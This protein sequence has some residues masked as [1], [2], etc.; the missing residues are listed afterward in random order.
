VDTAD[1][2]RR[3]VTLPDL[4][5]LVRALGH[6]T[7][8]QELPREALPVAVEAAAVVGSAGSFDWLAVLAGP[9]AARR[10]SSAL[11]GRGRL[12]G[13]L[14][15]DPA[16]GRL[17]IAVTLDRTA[18]S[19]ITCHAPSAA[20]LERLRRLRAASSSEGAAFAVRAVEIV[21]SEDVGRRFFHAFRATLD[22]MT[23]GV[24]G[25][26]RAE[27]RRSLALIQLT[28]V[29]F[30]Y[31]VQAKGWLDGRPDFLRRAVDET[32]A[33]RRRLHRD[34]FRPLFFG[35]L[36]RR[37]AD[38][39]RARA[40]GRI[41]FLNGGLFEPHP[42]ER[43]W[44]GEIPDRCW[45][46]AFDR[47]FE[48]FH[49]TVE[50]GGDAGR[51]APDMLGRVFEGVMAPDDRR[52]SGA[53][54][55]PAA[56]VARLVEEGLVA[57]VTERL[58][59]PPD[60]AR[61]LLDGRD[62]CLTVLLRDIAVLDPAVGS[63]AFLL[64]ALE[65]LADLR[66][67]E[68]APGALRR[69]ILAHNLFGVDRNPMAVR[70]AELRL[71]L[72][73]IAEERVP[74]P[75]AVLPLPNLD[76][77]VRQGDSLLDPAAS[78][79]R[80]GGRPTR[81][82]GELRTLRRAFI[83]TSGPGKRDLLRALRRTELRAFEECL[84]QAQRR[85]E[86]EVTECLLAA[87]TPT[88]F[89]ERRG[90]DA[91]LR[92]R[93]RELRARMAEARRLHRRMRQEG[94]VG[95]FSYECHFGDV[96]ARG[97]FDLIAGNP[98]WVR[99][100]ELPPRMREQL[101]RRFRWWRG[102]GS[103]FAHQPDLS[104]AFVERS[105]ELLGPGGAV[106]L[107]LPAKLAT[108]GYA[109]VLRG[110]LAERCTLH[111]IADLGDDPNASFEATIYPA[112]LVAT[113]RAPG[114]DHR[115]RLALGGGP[116]TEVAQSRFAGGGA[117]ILAAPA[118]LEAL[119]ALRADHPRLGDRLTPQL[120]VKTGA[121]MVF[122]DPPSGIEP[123]LIRLALRGRDV[124][125]FRSRP[126][127]RLFFPH[128]RHGAVYPRL[129]TAAASFVARHDTALRARVDYQDGPPWT[130]FRVRAALAPHRVVWPDLA[131]QLAAATLS[132]AGSGETIPLNSCYLVALPDHRSALALTA[133]LN[134]SWIRVAARA[135]AD[136][137]AGG[138]ARFNARVVAE[139]PLPAA[140]LGDPALSSLAERGGRGEIIQEELDA[141]VARHLA[142]SP[143]VRAVLAAAQD[144]G[145]RARGGS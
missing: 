118:L 66:H 58:G 56:L 131:R 123:A 140:V 60:Q 91:E 50:E 2:L 114:A 128:D 64:A 120:G 70:L 44:H 109:R 73:V 124:R 1:L 25:P 33:A 107:L 105:V 29:L 102:T 145:G 51:I 79:A 127:V 35:T 12:A 137:A 89:G 141:V 40:F 115:V 63:G 22:G 144:R 90:L 39:G 125:S 72:A 133:W 94:E 111:A 62:P 134:S 83:A 10:L 41:P 42:L 117:W 82:A 113:K 68:A 6:A 31:F 48:R 74:D 116:V 85:L 54:Y 75:E 88:L 78:L 142:L 7:T 30:L 18:M 98:P 57:L 106:V 80:L 136:L 100:E 119:E 52:A 4:R 126:S 21:E 108:A 77:V 38:R 95:W 97:G 81:S 14:A 23:D 93:L 8:W 11:A 28:R 43:A 76:G 61:R 45:R 26:A 92:R 3:L 139:L 135:T 27:D 19:V 99:A 16:T 112:A 104:L 20:D 24:S 36:N 132:G 59:V 34:L 15:L 53:F 69:R 86:A 138:F 65:R 122:L 71:W 5:R 32:L 9:P 67:R 87:R 55:T 37:P 84:E 110:Q 121:N 96:L 130:L 143:G 49:F 103:G 13:V 46:D 129:P 101:A 47:L 17:S